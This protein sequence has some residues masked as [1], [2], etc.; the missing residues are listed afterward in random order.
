MPTS[1][2]GR[3]TVPT[4]ACIMSL[5]ACV[6]DVIQHHVTLTVE[7]L[8]RLYLNVIQPRLQ[9][10]NGVAWFFRQHRGELFAT[11]KVLAGV[12][13]PFVEAIEQFAQRQG[14]DVLPFARNQR[15]DEVAREHLAV[16][17]AKPARNSDSAVGFNEMRNVAKTRRKRRG[18]STNQQPPQSGLGTTRKLLPDLCTLRG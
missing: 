4:G 15:K 12:T 8:D 18:E 5:S 2:G 17:G 7:C 14:L 6:A 10:E 1:G 11:A 9:Q 16:R 13:R 3:E